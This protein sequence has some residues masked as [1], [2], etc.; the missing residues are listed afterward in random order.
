[1]GYPL[2]TPVTGPGMFGGSFMYSMGDNTI[3]VGLIAGLDFHYCDFNP[4]EALSL[5]K[6]TSF[7]RQYLKG[8]LVIEAGAKM[9]PEG[10][11]NAIPRDPETDEIGQGN[12]VILGDGAGF[13]NM[14]QIKGLSNAIHSGM[15]AGDAIAKNL[16]NPKNIALAYTN[17]VEKSRIQKGMFEARNFRQTFAKLGT[18][19]GMP[20]SMFSDMLPAWEVEK[21]Y[22]TM[23][24]KKYPLKSRKPFDKATFTALAGTKHRE[25]QPSHLTIL[26][27]GICQGKC[28]A[29]FH[30]P[31]ITFCPGGVYEAVQ[32]VV[33]PANPSN[34]LH[35]KTCQRKCPFDNIRWTVPE[36]GGG[37]RHKNM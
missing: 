10:G 8:G 5:F 20:L 17:L 28:S 35:C 1:M 32:G 19:L 25:D 36:G 2:W 21:D 34:C 4:Q 7:A 27:A 29:K 31:C 14:L 13:V 3:A 30:C 37:P 6:K 23:S 15:L 33:K 16:E 26:D 12:T 24:G 9:I 22:K 18:T 11:L